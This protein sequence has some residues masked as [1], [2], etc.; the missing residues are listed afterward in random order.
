MTFAGVDPDEDVQWAAYGSFDLDG[1][2]MRY[3]TYMEWTGW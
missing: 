2:P 1:E 3:D